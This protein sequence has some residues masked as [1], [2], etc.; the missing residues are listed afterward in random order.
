MSVLGFC[1]C[2]YFITL[3][4]CALR[5]DEPR[6]IEGSGSRHCN[7]SLTTDVVVSN[8]PKAISDVLVS[9]MHAHTWTHCGSVSPFTHLSSSA[10]DRNIDCTGDQHSNFITAKPLSGSTNQQMYW[11]LLND[12]YCTSGKDKC[13][14]FAYKQQWKGGI[15]SQGA[16]ILN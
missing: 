16:G 7:N 2:C 3:A 15:H 6:H 14:Y 1:N 13:S 10:C 12:L 11:L 9:T 4:S 8:I 5:Q